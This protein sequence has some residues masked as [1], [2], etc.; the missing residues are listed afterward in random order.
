MYVRGYLQDSENGR[1][2]TIDG[3]SCRYIINKNP[4]L[5][6]WNSELYIPYIKTW[7]KFEDT[8]GLIKSLKKRR[9]TFP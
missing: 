4:R 8:E 1:V 6:Q 3:Q 9:H 7:E 5:P 2:V